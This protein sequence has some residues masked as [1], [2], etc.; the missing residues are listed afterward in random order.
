[1]RNKNKFIQYKSDKIKSL[2]RIGLNDK[3]NS[4]NV[5]KRLIFDFFRF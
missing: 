2:R 3:N 4:N 1:M 5:D